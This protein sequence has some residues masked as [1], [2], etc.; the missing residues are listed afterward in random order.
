[1]TVWLVSTAAA[2]TV[3]A[4][5]RSTWSPCGLSML[6]TVTP[7]AER[8]RGHRYGV[9]VTWFV[10]G[11]VLGGLT[12]GGVTAALAAG[13]RTLALPQGALVGAGAMACLTGAVSD[14]GLCGIH[15][16][17]H[18]RQVNERW[19]DRFRPWVYGAGF[20]WQIGCGMAT[21]ITTAAVYL[22]VVLGALSVRPWAAVALGGAFGL[23]R[24]LAV[25]LGRSIVDL[26]GLRAFHRRFAELGPPV[27][28]VTVVGQLAAAV[29]LGRLV[30]P[31]AAWTALLVAGALACTGLR[32]RARGTG[33]RSYSGSKAPSRPAT[34]LGAAVPSA[35]R[36]A[37]D[38]SGASVPDPASSPGAPPDTASAGVPDRQ[39]ANAR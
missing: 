13:V 8:A 34:P 20:G 3:L 33:P 18:H 26:D 35:V 10:L 22:V 11:S 2:V 38:R 19:L 4:G 27:A 7:L 12:L 9:T 37:S 17:V 32:R 6:A 31:W 25:L 1:M 15:L 28:R 16:P 30:A 39:A 29:V 21:Y 24:G 5:V 23:V 14:V 36:S